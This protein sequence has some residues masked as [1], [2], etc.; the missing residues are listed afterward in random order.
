MLCYLDAK[1]LT[2]A[3]QNGLKKMIEGF[4][5]FNQST[6]GTE[7]AKIAATVVNSNGSQNDLVSAE[8]ASFFNKISDDPLRCTIIAHR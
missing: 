6:N 3:Q 8:I 4:A 7:I 1:G 5:E 2:V